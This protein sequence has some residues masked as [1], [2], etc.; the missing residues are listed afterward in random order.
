MT[1]EKLQRAKEIEAEIRNIT[2]YISDIVYLMDRGVYSG[3][4]GIEAVGTSC[5]RRINASPKTI[6]EFLQT[7]HDEHLKR[8]A[9]L[10]E[11]FKNL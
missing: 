1:H 11:E 4:V 2:A 10:E 6:I 9:A 8:R 5:Y 3:S 7:V